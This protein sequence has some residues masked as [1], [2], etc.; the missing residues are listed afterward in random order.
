GDVVRLHRHRPAPR[1]GVDGHEPRGLRHV[2]V[3]P[4]HRQPSV[5]DGIARRRALV[6]DDAV[7]EE[8]DRGGAVLTGDLRGLTERAAGRSTR[9]A[10]GLD[11][12][13][14]APGGWGAVAVPWP[15]ARAGAGAMA[16]GGGPGAAPRAARKARG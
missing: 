6:P 12:A 8:G 1:V 15:A 10:N 16:V 4:Q 7:V 13:G 9:A 11:A 5:L 14:G 2:R 3:D